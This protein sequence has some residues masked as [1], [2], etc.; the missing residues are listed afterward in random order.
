MLPQ[1][2]DDLDENEA[3]V[4][5]G[6]GYY[7]E[8]KRRPIA[9]GKLREGSLNTTDCNL[10]QPLRDDVPEL[11]SII[12]T[13]HSMAQSMAGGDSGIIFSHFC[14]FLIISGN[15]AFHAFPG[16]PLIRQKDGVQIGV[17]KGF[18]ETFGMREP[19]GIF[20]R[21]SFFFDWISFV[22]GLDLP[23]C[24]DQAPVLLN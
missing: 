16:G 7:R 3:V 8:G 23:L 12:C 10:C 18:Y 15:N 11:Q 9:D 21:I 17:H 22:T 19:L 2:C 6:I 1:N 5:L 14:K 13:A 4:G 20:T 24:E